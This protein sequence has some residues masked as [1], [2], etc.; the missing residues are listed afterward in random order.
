MNNCRCGGKKKIYLE[1]LMDLLV[2]GATDKA[3]LSLCLYI[4]M[5]FSLVH[6]YALFER[7]ICHKSLSG[8]QQHSSFKSTD[9]SNGFQKENGSFLENVFI[10]LDYIEVIHSDH[11]P[12]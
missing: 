12:I 11:A 9:H 6:G 5:W 7:F 2:F 8:E 10:D 1:I 3:M 4:C